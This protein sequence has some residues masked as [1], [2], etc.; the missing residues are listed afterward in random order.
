MKHILQIV[1][2]ISLLIGC[3]Q[4]QTSPQQY[5]MTFII[6]GGKQINI[7]MSN[8]GAMSAESEHYK[9][10]VAGTKLSVMQKDPIAS[11]ISWTFGFV[12]KSN[13]LIKNV[14]IEYVSPEGKLTSLINDIKP[15][16][17]DNRWIG[18]SEASSMSREDSPWLYSGKNSIFLFKISIVDSEGTTI[19]YQPSLLSKEVKNTYLTILN[20]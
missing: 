4:A 19:L 7:P 13:L 8:G 3:A 17:K 5:N 14:V 1:L 20:N 6:D 15:K 16:L 2:T 11:K 10:V 9:V 12:T 18:D